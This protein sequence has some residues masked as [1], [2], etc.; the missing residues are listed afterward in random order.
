[1]RILTEKA[2][3]FQKINNQ[4]L[5]AELSWNDYEPHLAH[6]GALHDGVYNDRPADHGQTGSD[7]TKPT[8]E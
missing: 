8:T 6:R 3:L 7:I 2:P 1:V 4:T 5:Q